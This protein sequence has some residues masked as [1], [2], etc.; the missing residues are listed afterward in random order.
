M[1]NMKSPK[2][3][4][5]YLLLSG[6][7]FVAMTASVSQAY[8]Q[9]V[10]QL[11]SETQLSPS[12][13]PLQHPLHIL[14]TNDDGIN[15]PGIEAVEKALRAA[16]YR[17][18]IVAP[19]TQQ[20]ATSMKVTTKKLTYEEA[21]DQ[22]W[23]VI[24]SPADSIAVA[25]EVFLKND[26]PDLIISGANFGQN[27]GSNT[28]LSG[29]VGAALMGMQMGVP[30]IAISVGMHMK[31]AKIKPQRFPSTLAS[32]DGAAA[33]TVSLVRMLEKSRNHTAPIL[34]TNM[35]LN[36]NYPAL[37]DKEIKGPRLAAVARRGG[38]VA[39]YVPTDI[40]NELKIVL[41]HEKR[42][43]AE[44]ANTDIDLF[45]QGY[46]T[47]SVL[48]GHLGASRTADYALKNRLYDLFEK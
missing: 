29:T 26:T 17:L 23:A 6:L 31:E 28:N 41:K 2:I 5:L 12:E 42:T 43:D 4:T 14:L 39:A 15:A 20:S 10:S 34:P 7:L 8:A 18:S 46:I 37:D 44:L 24:G 1:N 45:N 27:L 38:F 19:K 48:E 36:V 32:F 9:A 40:P 35:I 11:S 3:P 21:G 13:R 47:I 22:R 30:G 16:N 25:L 33:F